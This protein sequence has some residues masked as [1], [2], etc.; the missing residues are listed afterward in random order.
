MGGDGELHMGLYAQG[1][2]TGPPGCGAGERLGQAGVAMRY[3]YRAWLG[4]EAGTVGCVPPDPT[5][6]SATT[7]HLEPPGHRFVLS[8]ME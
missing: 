6:T 3:R 5:P 2:Q 4:T 8:G 7:L 1:G